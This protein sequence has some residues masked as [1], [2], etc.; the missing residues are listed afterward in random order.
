MFLPFK[1]R[2]RGC[3]AVSDPGRSRSGTP[4]GSGIFTGLQGTLA[5][6][7]MMAVVINVVPDYVSLLEN[8]RL[9]YR[10]D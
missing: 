5:F 6:M 9:P 4:R 10:S 3:R 8:Y 1:R 2:I 7:L